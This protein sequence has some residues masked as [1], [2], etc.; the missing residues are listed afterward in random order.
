MNTTLTDLESVLAPLRAAHQDFTRAYP[1]D[2]TTRQPV[3]TVYSGAQ[4]V[5]RDAAERL[6]AAALRHLNEY[7]PDFLVFAEALGLPGVEAVPNS[8]ETRSLVLASAARGGELGELALAATVWRR[9][10]AKLER[11]PVEDLRIDFED[12]YGHRPDAEED[13]QALV[14]AAEVAAGMA[15]GSLPPFIGIRIK[16]LTAELYQRSLRTLDLFLT[17]LA[18]ATGGKLPSGFVVTLPKVTAREE[19]AALVDVLERLE[20]DLGFPHGS[21]QIELMVETTQCLLDAQ[22]RSALPGLVAAARGRCLG[23]HFGVYDYTAGCGL[24]AS[25]Q[26]MDHP[27]CDFARHLAQVALTG[28]GVVLS[29]GATNLMPVGPHR[30]APGDSLSENQLAENQRV[31]ERISRRNYLDVRHSLESGYYQGWDLH[32][33]QLPIRYAAVYAFFLE[34]LPEM[35]ARLRGF[36]D[37][38]A[39][40]TLLGAVFDDAAT[41]QALLNFFL[42]GLAC[43]A[44]DESEVLATGLT[45]E[46]I[47]TRSF[48]AILAARRG[49]A[50]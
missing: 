44:I 12:G 28:T 35:T 10:R 25:Q 15:A 49:N 46:E 38:A 18:A 34:Q 19:V 42:R 23:A 8:H 17:A 21:L 33:A 43:G 48:K 20:A 2:P 3:H 22:G 6:G 31:V 47:R 7:F 4:L 37:K 1:G 26:R 30:A 29:D 39:Q 24:I 32:P 41:G 45:L 27:V 11:E 16:P 50:P 40:A 9:V 14:A 13:A 5:R 36:I